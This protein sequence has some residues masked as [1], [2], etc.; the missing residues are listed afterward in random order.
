MMDGIVNPCYYLLI[1][2]ELWSDLALL[3]MPRGIGTVYH[4]LIII[5]CHGF[6]K[7]KT[8][9][10]TNI[11]VVFQPLLAASASTGWLAEPR[12]F[13]WI[14]KH[15]RF[16]N[17]ACKVIRLLLLI[18]INSTAD[19]LTTQAGFALKYISKQFYIL[20]CYINLSLPLPLV[21]SGLEGT[22]NYLRTLIK[23]R[24]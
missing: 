22:L 6:I 7:R 1:I 5:L 17:D 11:L 18:H 19:I 3:K 10:Q 12:S 9:K 15:C 4:S 24:F 23:S 13:F 21:T 20:L 2:V 8:N 16:K 14:N